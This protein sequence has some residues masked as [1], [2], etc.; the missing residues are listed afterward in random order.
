[1][2]LIARWLWFSIG[3]CSVVLGGLGAFLPV[4][5][6]TPFMILAAFCFTK[7]SPRAHAWLI[8]NPYFGQQVRDYYDG[9]GISFRTKLIAVAM[10]TASEA[11][12]LLT[13]DMPAVKVV[14]TIIWIAVSGYLLVGIPTRCR[15]DDVPVSGRT[16]T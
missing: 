6:T 1:M 4:L 11:Y 15:E 7:S 16:R 14:M 5:P 3:A 12:V 10:V 2:K 13:A 9:K 8:N